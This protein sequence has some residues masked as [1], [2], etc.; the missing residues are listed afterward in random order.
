VITFVIGRAIAQAVSRRLQAQVRSCGTSGGQSGTGAGFLRVLSSPLPILIPPTALHSSLFI[1]W[2]WYKKP[3]SGRI[4]KST[5]SHPN[6][7]NYKKTFVT[8]M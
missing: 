7:R 1:I 5:Q 3:I 8:I 4:T 2:G 6:P